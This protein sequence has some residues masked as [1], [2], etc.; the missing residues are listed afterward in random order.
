MNTHNQGMTRLGRASTVLILFFMLLTTSDTVG[1]QPFLQLSISINPTSGIPG[2]KV[3]MSGSGWTG[4]T[5]GHEIHWDSKTGPIL[6]TFSTNPNGAFT[7]TFKIPSSASP[8]QHTIWVCDRCQSVIKLMPTLWA[9]VNFNVLLPATPTPTRVPP[10]PTPTDVPTVCDSLGI[11][12][13]VVIDFESLAATIVERD[14]EVHP[15]VFYK[16]DLQAQVIQPD[17]ATKSSTRALVNT[18]MMEFG[19][20]GDPLRFGFHYLQDF[21]GVYV[22]LNNPRWAD[23][24]ITATMT[25]RGY[26]CEPDAEGHFACAPG[27]V[28]TDSVSFGPDPTPVKEC[29]S[30]EAQ[31]IFEVIIDYGPAADPEIIDN[32]T[33][34]GPEEPEPL[35]EDDRPPIV[36]IE[37][38]ESGVIQPT[39]QVRLQ[40]E[41]REDRELAQ[42]RY[43]VN[44]GPFHEMG[45]TS[46]GLTP[47]GE[48]LYLFAVDPLPVEEIRTC[49]DNLVE[50]VAVDTSENE[51]MG[52]TA[53]PVYYGDLVVNSVEPV[54]VI[55]GAP[56]I[57]GKATAFRAQIDSTFSCELQV[58]VRLELPEGEWSSAPPTSGRYH[59]GVP[60]SWEYP[61]V[62]GPYAI[63]EG[64]TGFEIMLPR[65]PPG[66]ED[67]AFDLSVHPY[68]LIRNIEAGGFY[69]PDVR[70]VPRPVADWVSFAIEI[71]PEGNWPETDEINN[72]LASPSFEVVTTKAWNFL[73]V[74][75]KSFLPPANY[76]VQVGDTLESV[77]AG[78][79]ITV[80]EI[81][82]YNAAYGEPLGED[83]Q[84]GDVI[85]VPQPPCV[86]ELEAIHDGAKAQMEYLLATFPIA[87]S[88]ITWSFPVLQTEACDSQTCGYATTWQQDE[89]IE[90]EWEDSC[91]VMPRIERQA[92]EDHDFGV[93]QT[94]WGGQS[95]LGK[96]VWV[97]AYDSGEVFAH[98]FNH[99]AV[100]M[101]DIY[102][103]DCYA[104][105]DERY[106]ELPD[107]DKF[108]CCYECFSGEREDKEADGVDPGQGC[109]VDCGNSGQDCESVASGCPSA[110][111]CPDCCWD[112]CE[113]E[114][115]KQGGNVY[116]AP[117]GRT[118]SNMP[119]P[120]GFWVN[121][122][123][124]ITGR[125]YFMDGPSG[126]NW[127]ILESSVEIGALEG[128]DPACGMFGANSDGYLNLLSKFRSD[129]DPAALLVSG[130][131]NR[132]A[133]DAVLDPFLR[134]PEAILDIEPGDA[135]DYIFFLLNQAGDVI[136]Q[137]GFSPSF[138]R[139]DPDGGPL[140]EIAF[141][142]RIEWK[143]ETAKIE[144]RDRQGRVLAARS[145]SP[146]YPTVRL[147]APNGG[148]GWRTGDR[149]TI[150]WEASDADGD[151]LTFSLALSADGGETWMPIGID[152]EGN[153][154]SVDTSALME[155]TSFVVRVRATDGVNTTEDVSDG[156]FT[157]SAEVGQFPSIL[158]PI[159]LG[160]LGLVGVGL[161]FMAVIGFIRRRA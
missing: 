116:G 151:A 15:G 87:D 112:L 132:V 50:V 14:M 134:L 69:G 106:C 58:D 71:D 100:P 98:E 2:T 141:A 138:Y 68:G 8:G 97:G 29:L 145:V 82:N 120:E 107:G 127:M 20:I 40:G 37:L 75:T 150:R 105:W 101:H 95:C 1:A 44:S 130:R 13:E 129:T 143:D 48:R 38:P 92:L 67:A 86:P 65:I 126:N 119:A 42:L 7:T 64:A 36:T 161:L 19:S 22:G 23:G 30:V 43:R 45:F 70:V 113:D 73:F 61:E 139:S 147:I 17:V 88:K 53:F 159:A 12:G 142:Y 28:G 39:N 62:W 103:L 149:H 115:D 77:A 34:R 121:R 56:L 148:E 153:R 131:I 25:A 156:T 90:A 10:T 108:Y 35:P 144:L 18:E 140:D 91:W 78:N 157:I 11:P 66:E 31:N 160:V 99:S 110:A 104:G 5:S 47:E 74:P 125:S 79:N 94:C 124:P 93:V 128:R 72:R 96:A 9:S 26:P 146:S 57:K 3:T 81:E 60:Q 136:S 41:V 154:Y 33:L 114:C 51:A 27:I 111:S 109:L 83:L 49:G 46:A 52:L 102:T 54:Q 118:Q 55:Y 16:G 117:D 63:P 4:N 135:G 152:L 123:L 158:I 76:F 122:W 137:S 85:L 89:N 24:P 84:A 21:A 59:T 32:L 155:G 80:E 133:S 6:E